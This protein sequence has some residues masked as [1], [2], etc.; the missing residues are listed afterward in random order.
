MMWIS[1]H[2]RIG[3]DLIKIDALVFGSMC[4]R[5][6][7]LLLHSNLK[8][9]QIL[10]IDNDNDIV[11]DFFGKCDV[12]SS[13]K[14]ASSQMISLITLMITL[15]VNVMIT[16]MMVMVIL[17]MLRGMMVYCESTGS[18]GW[19]SPDNNS[20]N[21]DDDDDGSDDAG[22]DGLLG[23]CDVASSYK[24][25]SSLPSTSSAT[26]NPSLFRHSHRHQPT[27]IRKSSSSTYLNTQFLLLC[28]QLEVGAEVPSTWLS[29][30]LLLALIVIYKGWPYIH[31]P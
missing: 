8:I 25:A 11:D 18:T 30:L 3:Q 31:Y 19:L 27:R 15:M 29:T 26:A 22:Y 1:S 14:S 5:N 10:Q 13:N 6:V 21:D 4:L 28:F 20:D 9:L 23:K 17:M 12:A 2:C 24:S 7:I 16:L